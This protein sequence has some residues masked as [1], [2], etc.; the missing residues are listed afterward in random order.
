MTDDQ[1]VLSD[2][3]KL[4]SYNPPPAMEPGVP[5]EQPKKSKKT[6]I[7]ILVIVLLLCCCVIVLG[8]VAWQFGDQIMQQL[9]IGGLLN[10]LI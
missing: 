1:T 2:S 3:N 4:P 7:I 5:P 6:W 8:V 10:R 9:G